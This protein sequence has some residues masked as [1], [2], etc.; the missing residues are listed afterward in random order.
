MPPA[1]A[2]RLRV[3]LPLLCPAPPLL[4]TSPI[5]LCLTF[6]SFPSPLLLLLFYASSVGCDMLLPPPPQPLHDAAKKGDAQVVAALIARKAPLNVRNNKGETPLALAVDNHQSEVQELLETNGATLGGSAQNAPA[7]PSPSA[8]AAA[9]KVLHPS[10][11]LSRL[12]NE[13]D[14]WC[15]VGGCNDRLLG[16]SLRRRTRLCWWQCAP[17]I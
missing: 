5:P 10:L 7:P 3:P 9:A 2:L 4:L 6:S 16:G 15:D 1:T 11:S 8:S 17:T 12:I 14:V 13:V